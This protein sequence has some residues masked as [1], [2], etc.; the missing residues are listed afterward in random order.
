[1][2][3]GVVVASINDNGLGE[4]DPSPA[5]DT[6]WTTA[7]LTFAPE[8]NDPQLGQP[9]EIR[10]IAVDF[11]SSYEVNFDDVKLVLSGEGAP[12]LTAT[13]TLAVNDELN[14]TPVEDTMTIDVYDNNCL[15][16]KAAGLAEIDP[17]DINADCITNI[18]DLAEM[19]L[20]WL[21]DYTLTEPGEKL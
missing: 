7:S 2:A 5:D 17:G 13:L 8:P 20:T 3:G 4:G 21:V 19:A 12:P 18:A 14:T 11:D 6:Y 15:A 9:L 10:L 1:M 16:A